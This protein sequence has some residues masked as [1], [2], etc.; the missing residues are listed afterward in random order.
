MN[1]SNGKIFVKLF[2][3]KVDASLGRVFIYV[4]FG[5]EKNFWRGARKRG[6]STKLNPLNRQTTSLSSDE[7]CSSSFKLVPP[8]PQKTTEKGTFILLL[9]I[10]N[11]SLKS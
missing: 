2:L 7:S 10:D 9:Y 11:H 4:D 8:L 1:F 6:S 3:E 5:V